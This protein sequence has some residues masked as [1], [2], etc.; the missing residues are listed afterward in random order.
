MTSADTLRSVRL[1]LAGTRE[2]TTPGAGRVR[3][4]AIA[5]VTHEHLRAL[6]ANAVGER[7]GIALAAVGS[8][9]RGTSGPLSDLDLVLVHD[10]RSTREAELT[11]LADRL[12]YPLW[13]S[14]IALDHSVRSAAECRSVA[15]EDLTAAVGLLDL[16]F[17]AGD[18]DLVAGVRSTVAHDWRAGARVRLPQFVE[19]V[20][21][22]H[23]RHG[24]LG[25]QVEPDLKEALGGLRDVTVLDALTR[26]WLTDRPHGEV[27][28][29]LDRLLDVRDALHVVTGRGRDRLVRDEH[30]AVAALLGH[31]DA[32]DLLT[33]VSSSARTI[34]WTLEGTMRRAGQSQRARTLR[35]GPRR[36]AMRPL[37]YGLFE[38]DGEVVLGSTRLVGVDPDL[39]LRAAVVAAGRGIPLSPQTLTNLAA[40][41][42]PTLP[43]ATRTRDLLTDLLAA[44]PGLGQVWEGLVQVGLLERW[45]PEWSAVRSRPQRSPVHR[46]TV[47]RHL[48]ETVDRALP[49]T[50]D[51][52][53]PDLLL[54]AAL[55][56][57]IGKV[58]GSRDHSRTGAQIAD[59]VLRR[60]GLP[61]ED[62]QLVVLLVRE[63]LA[64]VEAATRR[65]LADPA[66]VEGICSLVGH[67]ARTFELLRALTIADARAAGPAAWTD[68]RSGL[69]DTLTAGVRGRLTGAAPPVP[70]PSPV[71]GI[72]AAAVREVVA[73][74]P[75]VRVEAEPGGWTV[76][77]HCRDRVGLF[78]DTAGLL[79]AHGMT[80]RRARLATV[81]GVA[82]DEWFVESPGGDPPEPSRI[83]AGLV[84]LES[85]DRT[86]L[87]S[88]LARRG[89]T[90]APGGT[91][92]FVVPSAASGATVVE[93]RARDRPGLLHDLGRALADEGV[94]TRSAHVSTF[95]GRTLDTF[96]VTDAQGREL[97]PAAVARLLA[98]VIDAC[99][100]G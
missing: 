23:H 31:A 59:G 99:D 62:R 67:D 1:D 86:V 57:D 97:R 81:D 80:V 56:H 21:A 50:R 13:D 9:G 46:H 5:T 53:R 100:A 37:G 63:H 6:H 8:L 92:A 27:G 77:V 39:P 47:D 83:T 60:W 2:F 11:R 45:L 40:C 33:V 70:P 73:G 34:A 96:Y 25:Q 91:Q 17:V 79:A 76:V 95:A 24:E 43:W 28:P 14:G 3:R 26:A 20:R 98:A 58:A 44:G 84:R 93:V 85:G 10:G 65:D 66:T 19:S 16:S 78:A 48:L 49:L 12:W 90:P 88:A 55:L 36:P 52:D 75:H 4:E 7:P 89:R 38:H 15:R 29:A 68:W 42:D 18:P 74:R 87:R 69:V 32:D 41:P 35:V 54:L 94:S 72:D 51:V 30:D 22:R 71:I 61:D 82:V 64:L